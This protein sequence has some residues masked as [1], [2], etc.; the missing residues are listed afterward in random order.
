MPGNIN[1]LLF[2]RIKFFQG[3]VA[4]IVGVIDRLVWSK[5]GYVIP[6]TEA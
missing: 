2:P 4:M 3:I 5:R 1:A 6:N